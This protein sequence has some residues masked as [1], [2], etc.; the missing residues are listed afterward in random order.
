M[1]ALRCPLGCANWPVNEDFARC[2][3]CDQPTT[4]RPLAQAMP[5]AEARSRRNH[6]LFD[7]WLEQH[8]RA[9]DPRPTGTGDSAGQQ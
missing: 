5:A 8:G 3:I 4:Y 9:D 6:W 2:L 1:P 7:R